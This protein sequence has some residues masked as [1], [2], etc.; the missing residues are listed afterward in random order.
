MNHG[1]SE[2]QASPWLLGPARDVVLFLFPF[3]LPLALLAVSLGFPSITESVP[4]NDAQYVFVTFHVLLTFRF[5]GSGGLRIGA[6]QIAFAVIAMSV[7][8]FLPVAEWLLIRRGH[9]AISAPSIA[10]LYAIN[11]WNIATQSVFVTG[12]YRERAGINTPSDAALD[13]QLIGV[14]ALLFFGIGWFYTDQIPM[15]LEW[16][17]DLF[18]YLFVLLALYLF[19]LGVL[20]VQ[21]RARQWRANRRTILPV[22]ALLSALAYPWPMFLVLWTPEPSMKLLSLTMSAHAFQSIALNFFV[23]PRPSRGRFALQCAVALC[24]SIAMLVAMKVTA[25]RYGE[26]PVLVYCFQGFAMGLALLHSVGDLGV[27]RLSEQK[28]PHK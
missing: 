10:L 1:E 6:K 14:N 18:R 27:F 19:V 26:S 21:R 15:L 3:V 13:R 24:G 23:L 11:S 22:A 17:L 9:P 16:R 5:L 12:L 20:V 8:F 4:F 25:D 2:A 7:C 28:G